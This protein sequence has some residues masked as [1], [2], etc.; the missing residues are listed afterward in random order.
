MNITLQ[1][2]T[3]ATTVSMT[4]T[5]DTSAM[6]FTPDATES[7]QLAESTSITLTE[8]QSAA[9]KEVFRSE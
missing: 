6:E 5:Q 2:G 8:K 4:T 7:H 3:S 9:N 1:I